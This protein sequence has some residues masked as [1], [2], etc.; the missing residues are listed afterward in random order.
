[1]SDENL[2]PDFNPKIRIHD[3]KKE[4][5]QSVTAS[6]NTQI[7]DPHIGLIEAYGKDAEEA[8]ANLVE[9]LDKLVDELQVKRDLIK[10]HNVT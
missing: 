7:Q 8:K 9:L 6:V 4:K 10:Q 2:Y 1:M 5:W 3:D